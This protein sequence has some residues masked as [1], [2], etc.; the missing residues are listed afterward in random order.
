MAKDITTE[1]ILLD[2]ERYIKP[3]DNILPGDITVEDIMVHFNVRNRDTAYNYMKQIADSGSYDLVKVYQNSRV[4]NA[5]R[6]N[7][8]DTHV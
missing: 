3:V 1:Q 6:K 7:M 8:K 5:L 2:L 4:K